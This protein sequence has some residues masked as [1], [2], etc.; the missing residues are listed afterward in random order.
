MEVLS[1]LLF[2][3]SR[4]GFGKWH[5]SSGIFTVQIAANTCVKIPAVYVPNPV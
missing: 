1:R 4:T 3:I 5:A 2:R